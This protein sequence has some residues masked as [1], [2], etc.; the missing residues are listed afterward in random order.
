MH[1]IRAMTTTISFLL[2]CLIKGLISLVKETTIN[3]KKV[4][5]L[6][7][8]ITRTCQ[9]VRLSGVV[10]SKAD[11]SDLVSEICEHVIA[12]TKINSPLILTGFTLQLTFRKS[13]KSEVFNPCIWQTPQMFFNLSHRPKDEEKE[14]DCRRPFYFTVHVE[15]YSKQQLKSNCLQYRQHTMDKT[16][17]INSE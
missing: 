15:Q 6:H 8:V 12:K 2:S 13:T 3:I 4:T 10:E 5:R 1:K 9:Q 14:G 17:S 16:L 7:T 11:Q